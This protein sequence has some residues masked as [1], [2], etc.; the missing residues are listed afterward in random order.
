ME[1][2]GNPR[3]IVPLKN[4]KGRE[5][6]D[7]VVGEVREIEVSV[8]SKKR[9]VYMATIVGIGKIYIRHASLNW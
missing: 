8:S 5:D 4:V 6:N 1:W 3:S 2:P 7:V 9:A